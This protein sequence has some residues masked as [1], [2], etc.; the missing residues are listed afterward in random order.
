MET[1]GGR[2]NSV[3][4]DDARLESVLKKLLVVCGRWL[5]EVE[6]D[7]HC[8]ELDWMKQFWADL[9]EK[10]PPLDFIEARIETPC[11]LFYPRDSPPENSLPCSRLHC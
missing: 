9:L 1:I 7:L 3:V 8:K 2:A 6:L 11:F 5:R 10:K 4:V